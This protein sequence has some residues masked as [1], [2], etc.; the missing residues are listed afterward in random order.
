V[1]EE[2]GAARSCWEESVALC[3][4]I[5]EP[6]LIV[7]PLR[8]LGGLA[9]YEGDDTSAR[10]WWETT[11]A[12]AEIA[13]FLSGLV[14]KSL[15]SY[16]EDEQGRRRYRLL[17]T[18]RQYARDRL[19][20]SREGAAVRDRHLQLFLQMAEEA[21]SQ[22]VGPLEVECMERLEAEHD[23]LRAAL[24]WSIG[25]DNA[26]PGLRLAAALGWVW[27]LHVHRREGV[28]WL[29]QLLALP[30]GAPTIA[31]A[32]ALDAVVLLVIV[33]GRTDQA[34]QRLEESLALSRQLGDDRGVA[35]ALKKLAFFQESYEQ[36]SALAEE[37]IT[38]ARTLGDRGALLDALSWRVH[39]IDRRRDLER[40][41]TAAAELME[42]AQELESVIGLAMAY[43]ARVWIARDEGDLSSARRY[44]G[45]ELARIVPLKDWV[46]VHGDLLGM[47]ELARQQEDYR[48]AGRLLGLREA[49]GESTGLG[50]P[51]S[52]A[53]ARRR[54]A[55]NNGAPG[56]AVF[57]AACAEG[58][59]MS[60]QQAIDYALE[61]EET[62]P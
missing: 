46:G 11:I 30:P 61:A 58:R 35:M 16:E 5:G 1:Q 4:W 53:Q 62:T 18:V 47:A 28:Q 22:Y 9:Y 41:R 45:E 48:W 44:R 57:A 7:H 39:Q 20:E 34:R 54:L 2:P 21:Q 59:S 24:E 10:S 15:A 36:G 37:S 51:A 14:E 50:D 38:I 13:E 33:G 29:E 8:F 55:P 25:S 42:V 27:F 60:L 49:L 31:R 52:H 17:E 40:L 43:R 6:E 56:E 26:E 32:R 19:L 12:A 23:N 3:R